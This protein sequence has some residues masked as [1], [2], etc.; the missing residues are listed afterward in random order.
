M[1]PPGLSQHIA[2]LK[3]HHKTEKH[4]LD[5]GAQKTFFSNVWKRLHSFEGGGGGGG[6]IEASI[7]GENENDVGANDYYAEV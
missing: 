4:N 1:A 2:Q 5:R 7:H 6:N 3:Q